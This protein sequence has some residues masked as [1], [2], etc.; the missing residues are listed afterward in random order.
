MTSLTEPIVVI[1]L[2]QMGRTFAGAFLRSG[3]SVVPV[4][5]GDDPG[6]IA[7]AVPDPELALVAVGEADLH[8]TLDA[9]PNAWRDRVGLLQNELLPRDWEAHAIADPTVAVV[10]FE[11]KATTPITPIVST[12]VFGPATGLVVDAL[13]SIGL[14]AHAGGDLMYELIRKNLYILVANI[15]GLET[16]GT[17]GELWAEHRPLAEAVAAD[18]LD[19][20]DALTGTSHERAPLLEALEHD[21]Q[22]DPEHGTRGRSAPGRLQRALEHA[23]A[24][25]LA[26]PTL[27]AI[28]RDHLDS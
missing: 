10:W 28:A 15:A 23:A 20:Q 2:G 13:S 24:A 3:R 19:I 4:N 8:P 12:P 27:H 26:V 1:G 14:P 7:A 17:V 6:A 21:F 22:A 9:L 16:G 25:G 5:R 11:R 18:V